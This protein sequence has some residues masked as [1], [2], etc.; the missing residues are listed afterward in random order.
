MH[1]HTYRAL[2]VLVASV[3][4]AMATATAQASTIAAGS[5]TTHGAA[6]TANLPASTHL[7]MPTTCTPAKDVTL[8]E[9]ITVIKGSDGSPRAEVTFKNAGACDQLVGFASYERLAGDNADTTGTNYNQRLFDSA[10]AT[11][12]AGKSITLSVALPSCSYQDD[13]FYG[14]VITTLS[15]SPPISLY[16]SHKLGFAF[17]NSTTSCDTTPTSTKTP[18]TSV[19]TTPAPTSTKTPPTSTP[20]TPAPTS[21]KTPPTSTATSTKTPPTSTA[22]TPANTPVPV[23]TPTGGANTP[24]LGSGELLFAG[25]LPLMVLGYVARRRARRPN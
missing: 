20:T 25:L 21:T 11:V 17:G 24:E 16:G 5:R 15:S 6:S 14:P 22:T 4:F 8:T 13:A 12:N 7:R 10:T 18:P 2:G 3:M 9:T 1:K 19:P 23:T